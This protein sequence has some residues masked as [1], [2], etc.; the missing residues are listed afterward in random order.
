M[1]AVGIRII[2]MSA[3]VAALAGAPAEAVA[4][5]KAHGFYSEAGLGGTGLIKPTSTLAIGP[6]ATIRVGYDV[7]SWFSLGAIASVT[8]QRSTLPAPP[9]HEYQQ[10]YRGGAVARLGGQVGAVSLYLN[11]GVGMARVS[12]N[13]L[14]RVGF[15]EPGQRNS[16]AFFAGAG[17][18]YQLENRHYALGIGGDGW[19][20]TQFKSATAADARVY[21]RYTY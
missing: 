19:M 12:S 21:L 18:E 16:V 14:E 7:F 17:V 3:A 2:G 8:T 13:L 1:T 6:S 11:G 20:F 4:G 5:R 10:M 15:I 9:E